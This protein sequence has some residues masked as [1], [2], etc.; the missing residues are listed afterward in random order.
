MSNKGDEIYQ[1]ALKALFNTND[2]LKVLAV[3][4]DLYVYSDTI[5]ETP[6]DT[7]YNAALKDFV[8]SLTKNVQDADLNTTEAQ[9]RII[10]TEENYDD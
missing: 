9:L 1:D 4:R 3:W 10:T 7:Y 2:G 8:I 6:C 5:G